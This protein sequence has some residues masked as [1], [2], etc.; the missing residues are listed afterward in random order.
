MTI[1]NLPTAPQRVLLVESNQPLCEHLA[2]AMRA[3]EIKVL[4]AENSIEAVARAHQWRPDLIV[5]NL[6]LTD[7]SG[8]LMIAKLRFLGTPPRAW[9]YAPA[10]SARDRLWA[11]YVGVELLIYHNDSWSKLAAALVGRIR[12]D[13]QTRMSLI[14]G[15][16]D[17]EKHSLQRHSPSRQTFQRE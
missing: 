1:L 11:E 5:S 4:R 15:V 7:T 9:L 8:W 12:R 13:R 17:V 10:A 2:A 6:T 14:H 16:D 3:T